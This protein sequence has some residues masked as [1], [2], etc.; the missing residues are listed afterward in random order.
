LYARLVAI[1]DGDSH[2]M[3]GMFLAAAAV[4]AA[5]KIFRI[6]SRVHPYMASVSYKPA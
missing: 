4:A 3:L 6:P 2:Q 5:E 1:R